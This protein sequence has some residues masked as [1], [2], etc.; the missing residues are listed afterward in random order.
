MLHFFLFL[1]LD[2]I[3][4]TVSTSFIKNSNNTLKQLPEL[5]RK[6]KIG[7]LVITKGLNNHTLNECIGLIINNT[8]HDD[9]NNHYYKIKL[10][11]DKL[12]TF[13][14]TLLFI[15]KLYLFNS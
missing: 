4:N 10:C 7:T 5:Q 12:S 14:V 9:H 11:T 6:W 8:Y 3:I 1:F 15:N 13:N 2:I